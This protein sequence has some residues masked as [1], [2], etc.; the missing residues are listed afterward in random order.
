MS[1]AKV[2]LI[3]A[4]QKGYRV[5][6]NNVYGILKK[7]PLILGC[8]RSGYL[9]FNVQS[10]KKS[11]KVYVH[12]LVA[13]EKYQDKLFEPG[14]VVRHLNGNSK[15]NSFDNICIGTQSENLLD[16]NPEQRLKHAIKASGCIRKYTK[17]QIDQIKISHLNG[18]GYK[19]LM[20]K[21]KISSKGTLHY[22]LNNE[23]VT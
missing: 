4:Y 23:Y 21:F 6:D 8:S 18:L 7:E 1:Q 5:K 12:R 9:Y 16:R 14:V 10:E 19:A 3:H 2:A 20:E 15:D 11:R 22:I 13:Y 17:Q